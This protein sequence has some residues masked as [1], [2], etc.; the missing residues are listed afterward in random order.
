MGVGRWARLSATSGYRPASRGK[1]GLGI[2]AQREGHRPV[3]C[4][5]GAP[6]ARRVR[7]GRD[8]QGCRCP[9][10]PAAQARRGAGESA[11]GQGPG[12]VRRLSHDVAFISGPMDK[13]VPVIVTELGAGADPFMLHLYAALARKERALIAERTKAALAT[14]KAQG[15]RL[16]NRTSLSGPH[17]LAYWH[18]SKSSNTSAVYICFRRPTPHNI[19]KQVEST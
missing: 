18:L 13:R 11:Q 3:R 1:S 4:R 15:A 7:S 19:S 14:K 12:H 17:P 2:E 16:G 6:G 5:R 9:G 8:W 10:R